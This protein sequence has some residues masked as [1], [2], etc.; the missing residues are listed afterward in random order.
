MRW[1]PD[2]GAPAA[3]TP[4]P[5]ALSQTTLPQL[6]GARILVANESADMRDRT[7][8]SEP[9]V[10]DIPLVVLSARVGEEAEIEGL[11]AGAD[12]YLIKPFSARELLARVGSN[13]SLAKLRRQVTADLRD[14]KRL[15]E[16]A[17]ALIRVGI[18]FQ[19]CL[20][21]VLEAAI[22]IT[23]ADVRRHSIGRRLSV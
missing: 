12:D 20:D 6:E 2:G 9:A 11:N 8:S 15:R 23:R 1:L 7:I 17:N 19:E 3:G 21:D 14:T 22:E 18:G 5:S 4:P 16:V 10:A 13:L